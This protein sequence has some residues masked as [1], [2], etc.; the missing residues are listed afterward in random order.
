LKI[1]GEHEMRE[2]GRL[3][4]LPALPRREHVQTEAEQD[5]GIALWQAFKAAS[6]KAAG[7]RIVTV[8]T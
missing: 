1:S 8:R 5:A 6:R 4:G 2:A 7:V 3:R